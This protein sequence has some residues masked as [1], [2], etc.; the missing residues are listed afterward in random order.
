QLLVLLLRAA[1]EPHRCHAIA[2]AVERG[3]GR[4]AQLL[5]VGKAEI[6][7]CAEVE[8]GAAAC[9]DPCRLGRADHALGLVEAGLPEAV[10]LAGNV[11]EEIP[12]H[13]LPL[14]GRWRRRNQI[15]RISRRR[16]SRCRASWPSFP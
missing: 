4:L 8:Q 3:L 7:V 14:M 13:V 12:G 16:P 11:V 9:F 10:E 2:V 6:V 5:A 15:Y 1:D